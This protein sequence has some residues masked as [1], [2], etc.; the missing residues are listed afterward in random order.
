MWE[1]IIGYVM[2]AAIAAVSVFL[3]WCFIVGICIIGDF[4]GVY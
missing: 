2:M 4:L 1:N 3:V